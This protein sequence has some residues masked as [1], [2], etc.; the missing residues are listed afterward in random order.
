MTGAERDS[1]EGKVSGMESGQAGKMNYANMRAR[2]VALCV[3][4]ESG[5]R[6]FTE[7]QVESLGAKSGSVLDR[8]FDMARTAS[9]MGEDAIK[10]SAKN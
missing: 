9:G 3:C 10:N 4:D 7:E 6:V 5:S 1:Y 8:I 2:L